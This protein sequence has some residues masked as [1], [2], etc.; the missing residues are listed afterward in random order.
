MLKVKISIE[1]DSGKKAEL[2]IS[3]ADNLNKL[4]I[5]Q[6]VFNLFGIDTDVLDM[7]STF[8]KAGKAYSTFFNEVKPIED[9]ELKKDQINKNEIKEKL[10][11]G[12]TENKEELESTYLNK[13][14]TNVPEYVRT[15]IKIKDDGTELYRLRYECNA[16]FYKTSF[17]IYPNTKSVRCMKC[18]HS[19]EVKSAH[20][21]GFPH[22]D[23]FGNFFIAGDFK[24]RNV[25]S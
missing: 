18:Q 6:N 16:C 7:V 5:I 4:V 23:N 14:D 8:N 9:L 1:D 17:Y 10:I 12:F 15:G 13:N 11:K 20:P 2:E 3:E 24:D 22:Q 21:K 19:L 25:W